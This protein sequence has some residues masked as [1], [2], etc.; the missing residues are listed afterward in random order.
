MKSS[1]QDKQPYP[2]YDSF[3][4]KKYEGAKY[5]TASATGEAAG[6]C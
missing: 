2:W 4:L 3:W 1:S 5:V 6:F